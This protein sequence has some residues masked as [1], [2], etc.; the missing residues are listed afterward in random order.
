[1]DNRSLDSFKDSE[2]PKAEPTV[3]IKRISSNSSSANN[4]NGFKEISD[5]ID[6]LQRAIS[7]LTY[8]VTKALEERHNVALRTRE[9]QW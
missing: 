5:K 8:Q 4:I 1:M 9:G 2:T 6:A 7:R 3:R